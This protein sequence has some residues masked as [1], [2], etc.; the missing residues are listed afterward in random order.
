MLNELRPKRTLGRRGQSTGRAA[1]GSDIKFS[2]HQKARSLTPVHVRVMNKLGGLPPFPC[3]KLY[4]H[5]M[6]PHEAPG[7]E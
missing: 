7:T 4:C 1:D 2:V 5:R 6:S 3:L